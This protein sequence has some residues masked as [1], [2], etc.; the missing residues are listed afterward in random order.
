MFCPDE[1]FYTLMKTEFT[2]VIKVLDYN[3]ELKLIL[4]LVTIDFYDELNF[5]D[6][7]S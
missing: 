7:F 5:Q 4:V 1:V 3:L 2:Y 6:L